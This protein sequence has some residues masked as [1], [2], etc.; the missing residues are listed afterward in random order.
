MEIYFIT[1]L[2][3]FLFSINEI[4]SE[5]KKLKDQFLFV[6]FLLLVFVIGFRWET[7]TDWNNYL[8]TFKYANNILKDN[9]PNMMEYS[10]L[11]FN[12]IVRNFTS[13]YTVFLV[14]Q[15]I[16]FY[17][18]IIIVLR[19][20]TD[21]PQTT[22]FLLF[23][24]TLGYVGANRQLL[25]IAICFIALTFLVER[26]YKYFWANIFVASTVH[27][28]A[29][30][31][32]LYSI[33]N[34][35]INSIYLIGGVL[36]SYILGKFNISLHILNILSS[37]SDRIAFKIS[38]YTS[39]EFNDLD[40]SILGLIRRFLFLF[41]FI[42]FRNQISK[43]MKNYNLLLNGYTFSVVLYF[44]F[45]D[46]FMIF[47]SRGSIYFLIM[48]PLL[49]ASILYAFKTRSDKVIYTVFLLLLSILLMYQSIA[50]YSDL[51]EPYKGIFFNTDLKRKLY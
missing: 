41:L 39:N 9:K 26:K 6:S 51:F 14:L 24:S 12:S 40:L 47:V 15:A 22:L 23:S 31:F 11:L 36:F 30:I 32:G 16:I 34:R 7:G 1:V 28:S 10:F 18:I 29:Y 35:R 19:K 27:I 3:I 38:A 25:A 48:E 33:F 44:L 37:F 5:N 42:G 43:K 46:T 8:N 4:I 17:S 2:T 20:I 50:V 13:N 49:L 21:Y 45:K